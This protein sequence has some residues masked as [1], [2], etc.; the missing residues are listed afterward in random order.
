MKVNES[1]GILCNEDRGSTHSE[2][3]VIL[4]ETAWRNNPEQCHLHIRSRE[5]LKSHFGEESNDG[6]GCGLFQCN[7]LN[8]YVN[9]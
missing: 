7:S 5:D 3:S 6:A 9:G 8:A 1:S 4:Y 2:T